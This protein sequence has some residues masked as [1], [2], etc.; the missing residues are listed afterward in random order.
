[1]LSQADRGLIK[2]GFKADMVMLSDDM[3]VQEVFKAE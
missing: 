3:D 1:V 2:P